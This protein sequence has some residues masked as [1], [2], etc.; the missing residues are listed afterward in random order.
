MTVGCCLGH[1]LCTI[2]TAEPALQQQPPPPPRPPARAHVCACVPAPQPPPHTL[3]H[4]SCTLSYTPCSAV[5]SSRL[6]LVYFS[7]RVGFVDAA[8]DPTANPLCTYYTV[9][10]RS[11]YYLACDKPV[12]GRYVVVQL[13]SG[14]ALPSDNR[15][16]TLSLCEVQVFGTRVPNPPP[17]SPPPSPPAPSPPSYPPPSPWPLPPSPVPPAPPSPAPS[18]A[19]PSPLPPPSPEPPSPAPTTPDPPPPAP[20]PPSPPPPPPTYVSACGQVQAAA[21]TPP[22]RGT[23]PP[24]LPSCPALPA[25]GAGGMG[26]RRFGR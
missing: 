2:A 16:I 4:P 22:T 18:P 5:C 20:P 11:W 23:H 17:P 1:H 8:V 13:T 14:C 15:D 25:A 7:V 6:A 21:H 3:S 12:I 10:R 19:P 9:P 26:R 24:S